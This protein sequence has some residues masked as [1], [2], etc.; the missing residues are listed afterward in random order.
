MTR[1][2]ATALACFIMT[3]SLT[4]QE[5]RLL[6]GTYTEETPAE[7][8]YL[9]SFDSQTAEATLLDMAPS[10]NPSF[11]TLSPDQNRAYS[12][13]EFKDG[14]QGVSSF[15]LEGDKIRPLNL[16]P[17]DQIDGRDPCNILDLGET[18]ITSNYTG[19]SVTV[20]AL[21]EKDGSLIQMSQYFSFWMR[22]TQ[23]VSGLPVGEQP[24]NMHCAVKSP[25]GK[26]VFVTNLGMDCVHRY[27]KGEGIHPLG[28]STIAWR[29]QG[30]TKYGPRHMV[31]SADGHFAYLLCELG[32]KLIVFEYHNGEL[33]PIQTLTAYKGKGHGSADIH[34]SPDGRF[35][36]TSHRLKGDGIAIFTIDPATGKV[37]SAGF[38]PTGTHPRNFAITP[39]GRWLLCACR[40]DDRIEIYSIDNNTGL[41][42]HSGKTIDLGA[43]VCIQ[44]FTPSDAPAE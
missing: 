9:Y 38:Q 14:R 28:N 1:L 11:V 23:V 44:V 43:P 10:G 34:I 35:L 12:V 15:I 24:A 27:D 13:N 20:F 42:T 41:L 16:I 7:G 19:G 3:G 37:R 40:D 39:D 25:D 21:D 36:Y 8:V 31:F 18:V 22:Y 32:D 29:H 5:Y 26:Y 2:I 30:L 33:F 6:V 17:E 4:A